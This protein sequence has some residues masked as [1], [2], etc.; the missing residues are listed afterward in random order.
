MIRLYFKISLSVF[1]A[2]LFFA[3][4]KKSDDEEVSKITPGYVLYSF[5]GDK[6][7]H[8]I[9][10][11]GNDVKTWTSSYKSA[12]GYYL[13]GNKTLLRLGLT[14]NARLGAFSKGGAVAG[15]IEELD[16]NSNVIWSMRRDSDTCTF[17]HDFKEIDENT[18]IALSWE[19]IEYNNNNFWNENV[20]IIDKTSKSIIWEWSAFKDGN[21]IPATTDNDDY[22]HFN[23]VDYKNNTILISARSQ[24]KVYL[25]DRES[26]IITAVLTIGN[27]LSGQHDATFLDNGNILIFNNNVGNKKSVVIEV[28]TSDEVFWE[29]SNDFYSDHIS[30]ASRLE[31]G[32]TLICS[33]VEA[34]FIE[35]TS[36]GE[37]VWDYTQEGTDSDKS[38]EVFKVRKYSNY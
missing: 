11:M 33:G 20:Q 26:K 31:S 4:E 7:T 16:D 1:I 22:L 28:T 19:L 29:Y 12:G 24:N 18:I 3:C 38:S 35:V 5:I 25:I 17:H 32:N 34:R 30:G 8:L 13:S 9:D 27:T 10:S 6:T 15:I 36:N 37:E 14:E 23:S 21:I 2:I